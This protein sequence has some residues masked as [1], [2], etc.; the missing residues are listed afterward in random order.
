MSSEPPFFHR[1]IPNAWNTHQCNKN[2]SLTL[3]LPQNHGG[4]DD[5]LPLYHFNATEKE[6]LDYNPKKIP[7]NLLPKIVCLT[8]AALG[9]QTIT[10]QD[11][12]CILGP[13]I[14]IAFVASLSVVLFSNNDTITRSYP[15][16]A[17]IVELIG[18]GKI[19]NAAKN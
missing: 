17:A 10:S 7:L 13:A 1:I 3:T 14:V 6:K 19:S 4:S 15:R 8:F 16:L 9:Y 11:Q 18:R 12:P 2:K 5:H